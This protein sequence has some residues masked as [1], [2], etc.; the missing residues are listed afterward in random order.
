MAVRRNKEDEHLDDASIEA[1][2]KLLEDK[3]TKKLVCAKLNISYNVARLDKIIE[4][5]KLKKIDDA[6]RRA[7]KRGKAATQDE[8][9]HIITEYL[10]G[11]TLENI[12]K[13]L[14]RGTAF[15]KSVLNDYA[16]PIR[17]TSQDYFNPALIPDGAVR[18][19]FAVGETVYSARYDSLAKIRN[20]IKQKEGYVYGIYLVS[21]KWRENAYQPAWELAS[22]ER[23]REV[24]IK[25]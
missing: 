12:S 4:T 18:E 23:L 10:E 7:E 9:Q 15:I 11:A 2:I 1:A 5:Y 21:D 19:R 22:L 25:L 17:N 6:R 20:E 16:V 8:I 24:G 3:A 13:T 14:Y